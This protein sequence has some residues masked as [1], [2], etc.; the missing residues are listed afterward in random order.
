MAAQKADRYTIIQTHF[1][2]V[3][4]RLQAIH[5]LELQWFCVRSNR[6]KSSV[7]I[8]IFFDKAGLSNY[9]EGLYDPTV[10]KIRQILEEYKADD[11]LK[12]IEELLDY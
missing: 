7:D 4:E 8:Y 11:A 10:D 9:L 3:P 12:R 2:D 6:E 1:N 5:S